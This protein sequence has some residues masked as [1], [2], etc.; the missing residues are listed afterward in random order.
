M[1]ELFLPLFPP[2]SLFLSHTLDG[3]QGIVTEEGLVHPR[4]NSHHIVP[5]VAH[6]P[7]SVQACTR[8]QAARG[9][10]VRKNNSSFRSK[11]RR[12]VNFFPAHVKSRNLLT[13]Q[14]DAQREVRN[15]GRETEH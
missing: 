11:D 8:G 2:P 5:V 13:D 10:K 14:L 3:G 12:R 1:G 15:A 7:T 4:V 9:G 6:A